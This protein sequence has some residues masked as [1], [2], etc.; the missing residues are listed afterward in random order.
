MPSYI[1]AWKRLPGKG[2]PR[3]SRAAASLIT[4]TDFA[5]PGCISVYIPAPRRSRKFAYLN[6]LSS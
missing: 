4:E 3:M 1:T 5:F 6:I 2:L